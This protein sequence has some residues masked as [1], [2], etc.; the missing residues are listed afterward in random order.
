VASLLV[1]LVMVCVY[2]SL[3]VRIAN[4]INEDT[5]TDTPEDS[6]T[7]PDESST[8]AT[9]PS[10]TTTTQSTTS[11]ATT[12]TTTTTTITTA[13]TATTTTTT[14]ITN[15]KQDMI[16]PSP[17]SDTRQDEVSSRKKRSD[18]SESSSFSPEVPYEKN[19]LMIYTVAMVMY[20]VEMIA[21]SLLIHGVHKENASLMCLWLIWEGILVVFNVVELVRTTYQQETEGAGHFVQVG[22]QAYFWLVVM[23]YRLTVVQARGYQ[24]GGGRKASYQEMQNMESTSDDSSG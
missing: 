9:T 3:V 20:V 4:D 11:S 1:S 2:A 24:L 16:T 6:S 23:S 19:L 14:N 15:L 22:V 17:K 10:T 21:S 7:S 8:P 12:T 18:G 5:S 13:S